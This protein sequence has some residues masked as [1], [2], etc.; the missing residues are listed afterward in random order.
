MTWAQF[1]GLSH[2]N[3]YH[4]AHDSVIFG[5]SRLYNI[6]CLL[7]LLW[8]FQVCYNF[9]NLALFVI[10]WYPAQDL[11][12]HCLMCTFSDC[13][14]GYVLQLGVGSL[15]RASRDRF[16]LLLSPV[17]SSP[18]LVEELSVAANVIALLLDDES[19]LFSFTGWA[20]EE[21]YQ[22][23][24]KHQWSHISSYHSKNNYHCFLI[25]FSSKHK[26]L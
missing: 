20:A 15:K 10:R 24:S 17:S 23:K 22:M 2:L 7:H 25:H 11:L 14:L 18:P 21:A 9:T 1:Q 19:D 26:I 8:Y 13:F 5:I 12:L 4:L 6:F 16:R 3:L